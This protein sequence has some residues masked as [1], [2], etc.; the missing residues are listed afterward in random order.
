[1]PSINIPKQKRLAV[2]C[3][4]YLAV[5]ASVVWILDWNRIHNTWWSLE[6]K[7]PI[8]AFLAPILA[9]IPVTTLICRY[10]V[11]REKKVAYGTMFIGIFIVTI[12]WLI[13]ASEGKCFTGDFWAPAR[14][15]GGS[16]GPISILMLL[17]FVATISALPA[18]GVVAYYQRRS[19]KNE[20]RLA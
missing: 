9:T 14:P 8:V 4:V 1:M 15:K 16:P 17:G 5:C 7:D 19:N 18:F 13:L 6:S 11:A 12:I 20:T 3:L 10:R 2:V